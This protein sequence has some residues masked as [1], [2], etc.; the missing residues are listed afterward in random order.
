MRYALHDLHPNQFE[1]LVVELCHELLGAGV[2]CFATG[3]DGGRDAKF[4][5]TAQ[6]FPSRVQ[7]LAGTTIVQ[8]K[9]TIDAVGIFSDPSF[10]GPAA[11]STLSEE[12]PRIKALCDAN[13]LDHYLLFSNRRLGAIANEQITQ[14]LIKETGA[15]SVHLFGLEQLERY[16]KRYSSI[17]S[18]LREFEYDLPLRASPDELAEVI[19]AIA[20]AHSEIDWPTSASWS[21]LERIAFTK[22]NQANRLSDEYARYITRNYLKHFGVVERFLADP[23]NVNVNMAYRNAVDEFA[24]KL[25]VY[26][27]EFPTY[28]KLLDHL[29]SVLINRDGDLSAHKRLTRTVFYFMYWSCDIGAT[30]EEAHASAE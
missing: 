19:I 12:I 5:G 4:V 25:I 23:I 6:E 29:I 14:R 30:E 26:R 18:M 8:A 13:Q 28:D 10:S 2:Q 1:N 7:P 20:D 16:I 27:H 11:S 9:H 22:K 15:S 17:A 21:S 24:S 3:P